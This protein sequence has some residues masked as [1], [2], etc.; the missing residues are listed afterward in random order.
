MKVLTAI[1]M[2]AFLF[3]TPG[4]MASDRIC[5]PDRKGKLDCHD[6]LTNATPKPT[7]ANCYY[8]CS[9]DGYG[10]SVCHWNCY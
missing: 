7:K 8:H 3:G 10:G 9:P 4:A 1:A 2:A 6:V 5:M